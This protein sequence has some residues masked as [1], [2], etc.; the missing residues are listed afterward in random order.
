ML[1]A[2]FAGAQDFEGTIK[3]SMKMNIT[4]PKLK[5]QMEQAEKEMKDPANQEKM[6]EAMEQMNSPEIK[7][8]MESNPQMEASLKM[9]QGG[10]M[11]SM[12]PSGMTL[13]T[14]NGNALSAIEGGMMSGMET[15]YLKGK[16]ESYLINR[17]S[18]TYSVVPHHDGATTST[19]H[20]PSVTVKKTTETQKILNYTCTKSIVTVTEGNQTITQIFWT[21]TEIKGADFKNFANQVDKGKQKMYYKDIEGVPLRM[22]MT[23]PQGT[24]VMQVTEIKKETLSS[25]DFQI[26]TGFT[27]TK[28]SGH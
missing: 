11:S 17:T 25:S 10:G 5:A 15:L 22:E 6:K 13:K 19:T 21:T 14:K 3:W 20:D 12:M 28:F 24:M 16:S 8:M 26:P 1:L 4:D 9:M 18:K 7:K 2:N 23:M 27:E